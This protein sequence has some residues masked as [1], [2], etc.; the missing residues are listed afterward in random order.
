MIGEIQASSTLKNEEYEQN[1][2]VS[3]LDAKKQQTTKKKKKN[4]K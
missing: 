2:E 4:L 1:T 3:F